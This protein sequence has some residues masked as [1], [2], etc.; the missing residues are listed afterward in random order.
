[1]VEGLKIQKQKFKIQNYTPAKKVK[2]G[3]L[4]YMRIQI[5]GSQPVAR[6]L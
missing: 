4:W 1:M 5:P 3:Q 2:K 6:S